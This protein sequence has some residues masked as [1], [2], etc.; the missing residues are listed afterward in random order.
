MRILHTADWHIGKNL[1]GFSLIEDQYSI[2]S[3]LK[4][5]IK[6]QQ[7]DVLIVAGDIYDKSIP[8]IDGV[9][10]LDDILFEIVNETHAQIFMIAGNHDNATRLSFGN[11]LYQNNPYIAGKFKLELPK[12]TLKD[13]HGPVN[14][15]LLPYFTPESISKQSGRIVTNFNDAF[16]FIIEHNHT[17]INAT[18]R[19]VLIAHGFFSYLLS[20]KGTYTDLIITEN[21][22]PVGGVDVMDI[23]PA[24]FFDYV[25]LGHIHSPQ[26]I[27]YNHIAY[28]GSLLKYAISE[29]EHKKGIIDITLA[30]KGHLQTKL[31]A[32]PPKR[33][34][35]VIT[36]FIDDIIKEP[37]RYLTNMFDYVFVKLQD[38]ESVFDG[39]HRL[40]QV[41]ENVLGFSLLNNFEA[42]TIPTCEAGHQQSMEDLFCQ[43]FLQ[44]TGEQ[45]TKSQ[46]SIIQQ[47]ACQ[48]FTGKVGGEPQ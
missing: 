4:D 2:L 38:T 28:A 18:E 46:L 21:E 16:R 14:F 1:A 11:R 32:L 47:I 41:F 5:Y 29:S 33:D 8:S 43:F 26:N 45:P 37:N 7:I 3:T 27:Y 36:G 30:E 42:T 35:K 19:N 44:L 31:V 23:S 39:I 24:V 13:T 6:T 10:L 48:Q 12:I 25:A 9:Q 34:L 17:Q 20:T 40:R 15:F 22:L